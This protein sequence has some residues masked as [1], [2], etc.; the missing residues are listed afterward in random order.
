MHRQDDIS[1]KFRVQ[2]IHAEPDS[3]KHSGVKAPLVLD[4]D[5]YRQDIAKFNLT[6][7]QENILLRSLWDT[8]Q[9]F[10]MLG[11][12]VDSTQII[13]Q[14][15]VNEFASE[16]GDTLILEE[17]RKTEKAPLRENA[18]KEADDDTC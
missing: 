16:A 12:G 5:E 7:E 6:K 4:P 3:L 1:G 2:A 10:V 11:F 13:L 9:G 18:G 14:S 8:M 15:I 17:P